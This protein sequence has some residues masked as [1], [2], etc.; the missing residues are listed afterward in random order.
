MVSPEV[1][2]RYPFFGGLTTEE[3][4]AIALLADETAYQRGEIVFD[5]GAPADTFYFLVQGTVE[6]HYVV[7]DEIRPEL[8]KDFLISEVDAGEPFGISA[9]LEPGSYNGT[10]KAS[11]PCKVLRF[12]AVGLRALCLVDKQI[13][14]TL[15]RQAAKAALARL[16]ATRVL[17]AAAR[18]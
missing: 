8:R 11:S 16:N 18:T 7:F 15:M 9:L 10:V 12:D 13:A 3:I 6:L 1:L 2:K 17:L 14:S 4:Q 5:A